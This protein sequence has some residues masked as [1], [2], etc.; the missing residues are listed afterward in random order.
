[1]WNSSVWSD[2][3]KFDGYRFQQLRDDP[4]QSSAVSF[5]SLSANHMGFGY[6][7]HACPGRFLAA[8]EAKVMLCHILLKYDFEFEDKEISGAQTEGVMIWRDH[9]AQLRIKRRAEEIQL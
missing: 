6:G 1:M 5:V 3:A 7:K 2:A 9:R 8:I 4:D